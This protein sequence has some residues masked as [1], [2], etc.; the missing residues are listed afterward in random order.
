ML[1]LNTLLSVQHKSALLLRDEYTTRL[2]CWEEVNAVSTVEMGGDGLLLQ[3]LKD[4][5]PRA[6]RRD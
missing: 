2:R 1:L 4:L 6:S 5:S 3:T